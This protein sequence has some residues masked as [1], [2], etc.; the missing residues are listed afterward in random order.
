MTD[1]KVGVIRRILSWIARNWKTMI[2][3]ISTGIVVLELTVG[4]LWVSGESRSEMA[5][6]TSVWVDHCQSPRGMLAMCIRTLSAT[7]P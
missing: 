6:T 5:T 7:L 3:V 4:A 1:R 2:G